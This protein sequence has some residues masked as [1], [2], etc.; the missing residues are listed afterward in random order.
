MFGIASIITGA[1]SACRAIRFSSPIASRRA[2]GSPLFARRISVGSRSVQGVSGSVFGIAPWPV[3]SQDISGLLGC[4]DTMH[5]SS[6][7]VNIMLRIFCT[8]T[9]CAHGFTS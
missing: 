8:P 4:I 3:V 2:F 5:E 7:L 9:R 6:W 1:I